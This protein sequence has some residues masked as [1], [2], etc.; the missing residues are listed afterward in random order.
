MSW[1]GGLKKN[2]PNFK[3]KLLIQNIFI[4]F[5]LTITSKQNYEKESN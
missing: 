1:W 5:V 2:H 4:T 3:K